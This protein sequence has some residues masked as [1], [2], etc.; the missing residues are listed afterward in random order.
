MDDSRPAT[1]VGRILLV[2]DDRVFGVWATRVLEARGFEIQHVLDPVTG[3][4]QVEAEPWDLVITD[5]EMP[6][7]SGLEF[8]ERLRRL[9]PTLPV[10]VVTAH[11]TV[12]RAVTAMRQPATDFIQKP[13]TPDDFAAKITAL[14][15]QDRPTSAAAP[16]S[17]LAI[18]AHPGD[19]EIGAAGALLAHEAA[20]VPVTIL[21]LSRGACDAGTESGHESDEAALAIGTRLGLDDLG[22]DDLGGIRAGE[23]NSAAAAIEGLIE[24]I[25]PTVVYTHSIHDAEPAHRSAHLA[26]MAAARRIG[27]VYCFQSPSATI[28]FRPT[29]FVAIDDHIGSKLRAVGAFASQAEVRDFL[30][31]DQVTSTA[32]Y[33]SRYCEARN[34]EAFEVARDRAAADA[35]PG[36][37]R[38][39]EAAL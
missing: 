6:R 12:D 39:A 22:L 37:R 38:T 33:W 4:R 36:G 21:T 23:E 34:A 7:M 20:G 16:E 32:R 19:V 35:A 17:V 14:L 8:L 18:G 28:D 10:A 1:P 27:R 13:I 11:S 29:R 9:E 25:R 3:L 26:A 5:V 31:P 15:A 30:E 2:D 24:Q